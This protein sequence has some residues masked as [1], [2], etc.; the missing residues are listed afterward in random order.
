VELKTHLSTG[1]RKTGHNPC[2]TEEQLARLRR[3]AANLEESGGGEREAAGRTIQSLADRVERL[4]QGEDPYLDRLLLSEAKRLARQLSTGNGPP[5]RR[6]AARAITLLIEEHERLAQPTPEPAPAWPARIGGNGTAE[7]SANGTGNGNGS[8]YGARGPIVVERP[9]GSRPTLLAPRRMPLPE[10]RQAW[11]PPPR[12]PDTRTALGGLLPSGRAIRRVLYWAIGAAIVVGTFAYAP[13]LAAPDIEVSGPTSERI[14][15]RDADILA[16][17]VTSPAVGNASWSLD[18]R[19]V[20]KGVKRRGAT[21]TYRAVALGE[22]THEVAVNVPGPIPGA[23]AKHEWRFEIDLTPPSVQLAAGAGRAN[24]GEGVTVAGTVSED[25]TVRVAGRPAPVEKRSFSLRFATAPKAGTVLVA[26]TD[27]AG[28][29][30]RQRVPLNIIP[31][32][33]ATPVRGV[34]VTF[35]AWKFPRLR[36]QILDL[37]DAGK[38]SV[39]ELDLKDESGVVGFGP[40]LPLGERMGAVHKIYDLE[41]AVDTLH[42]KGVRVIGRL[43][44]FRDPIHAA[45]AWK[46]GRKNEVVQTPERKPYA[47]YG[48]F[49]NFANPAVRQYNIDIAKAAVAAGVDE[50]LYD[51]ARRPDGPRAS[52]R[53]PGLEG[54]ADRSIADFLRETRAQLPRRVFLGTSVFGVAASRPQ[55]VAQN[56]PMM[57]REL[58]FIAPM[59]YPSHWSPGEYGVENPNAQPYDI[60]YAALQEFQKDVR[61]TGARLVPWLQDFSLGYTYGREEVRAQMQAAREL[62][63]EEWILWNPEARYT[64]DA[65]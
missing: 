35:F 57:A 49:T 1:C 44:A 32:R 33:P 38:V 28:N 43:V 41:K 54:R 11:Q 48:G 58:D 14:G 2:V 29:V 64:D 27:T 25:A 8:G 13:R 65:L 59:L 4:R 50:I 40:D 19:T 26:A 51:Y 7:A 47:G 60:V 45:A 3:W 62:G 24:W 46:A 63:V 20:E 61:G 52:M 9:N 56:V 39:V 5:A 42:S 15:M 17:S 23:T 36:A 21:S 10:H 37:V 18:G 31:R 30:G 12:E 34:H 55:D 6:S 53:F 16:F 22:G